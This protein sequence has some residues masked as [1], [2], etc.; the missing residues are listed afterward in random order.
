MRARESTSFRGI[1]VAAACARIARRHARAVL[2]RAQALQRRRHPWPR[3][4][5][6]YDGIS[7]FV[8]RPRG[9]TWPSFKPNVLPVSINGASQ[10]RSA[11]NGCSRRRGTRAIPMFESGDPRHAADIQ[12]LLHGEPMTLRSTISV[13]RGNTKIL[14]AQCGAIP[15]SSGEEMTG[16]RNDTPACLRYTALLPRT[17]GL[18]GQP[19]WSLHIVGYAPRAGRSPRVAASELTDLTCPFRSGQAHRSPG[20]ASQTSCNARRRAE[21]GGRRLRA[22]RSFYFVCHQAARRACFPALRLHVGS[23]RH[24]RSCALPAGSA[25]VMGICKRRGQ[26]KRAW[27]M[28]DKVRPFGRGEIRQ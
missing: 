6:K 19:A 5:G 15:D 22:W 18:S 28:A 2:R 16:G 3:P 8:A 10:S 4:S 14:D 11:V 13:T 21:G 24:R 9:R 7:E 17:M 26:P 12:S 1:F 25:N 23:P 20:A 27:D